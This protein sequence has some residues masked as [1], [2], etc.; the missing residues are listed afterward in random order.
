MFSIMGKKA[1]KNSA[2]RVLL[3]RVDDSPPNLVDALVE[4]GMEVLSPEE[5]IEV[6][7]TAS[8]GGCDVVIL[9]QDLL[10]ALAM[11][12]PNVLRSVFPNTYLP[13]LIISPTDGERRCHLLESGADDVV[14]PR[15]PCS[16]IVARV[17]A[18]LRIKHSCDRI[19]RRQSTL[20]REIRRQRQALIKA[21]KDNAYLQD[22]ASCDSLTGLRNVRSFKQVLDHEFKSARRYNRPLSLLILDVDHF[23]RV[24][25][26]FGHPVGDHALKELSLVL[27]R[28]VRDSDVVA[29]IGGEEFAV[30]LP[31]ATRQQAWE[32]AE[33]IRSELASTK[34]TAGSCHLNI[35]VSVGVA[36]YPADV[37]IAQPE[38]MVRFSDAALLH[39]KQTGRDRVV[40]FC[41]LPA[42]QRGQLRRNQ[43]SEEIKIMSPA[44]ARKDFRMRN[45]RVTH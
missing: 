1:F 7:M 6:L 39:A 43:P 30:I 42:S 20:R 9:Q 35:T 2:K 10:D 5:H 27:R 36:T 41:D 44:N 29:R 3:V 38:M 13:V 28:S 18:L 8:S 32:F 34:I 40:K 23:K 17:K 21:R 15:T 25:D 4:G 11:D 19:A 37:E 31:H 26:S 12:M 33:R 22:L 14:S 16:E 45:N 24:N